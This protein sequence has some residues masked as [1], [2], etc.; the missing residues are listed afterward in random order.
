MTEI[1][2]VPT[3]S[4]LRCPRVPSALRR[5]FRALLDLRRG[6]LTIVLPD[7]RATRFEGAQAGPS[8]RLVVRS[9]GFLK[10]LIGGDVGFAD[11]YLEEEWATDDLVALL[12]LLAVN[13]HLIDRFAANPIARLAQMARH[14]L[15][16]NTRAGSRRNIHAHYDLGNAFYGA[17]LDPSMTYSS[18]LAVGDD[19]E[20]AQRR[21][22]EAMARAAGIEPGHHVLEIGCGWGGFA[23]YAA[24]EIG[25]RVTALTISQEQFA[26]ARA[27][28]AKAGLGDRVEIVL[29]DYRDERGAYDA[30]VS[31]EMIEAVGE[32]FWP[33]YFA[34]LRERLKPGGR[35]ALQAITIDEAIFPRYR[36]EMDFI[37]H[38]VFPGGML[39]TP[40]HLRALGSGAGLVLTHDFG[41]GADYARTCRLW[42]LRFEAEWPQIAALGFDA[43]FRRLWRYYLA[44]CEAGFGAGS[45]DVR[46]VAF[47]RE[48]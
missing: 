25:C 44:Y 41:F 32:A 6:A 13:Q 35:A 24:R 33:T 36:R 31:I 5:V 3:A 22:Y 28:I 29:R 9:Y 39:P 34:T 18:G 15:N 48:P 37:R 16:R 42:R 1:V 30:I 23:E 10:R 43:R 27:R 4:L 11:G 19:L 46:H 40:S 47:R 17:W 38:Y 14:M 45:I 21:K 26:F 20:G 12:A 2:L 8:A 7:G